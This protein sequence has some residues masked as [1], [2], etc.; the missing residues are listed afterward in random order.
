M[1][2]QRPRSQLFTIRLWSEEMG[3]GSEEEY[4]GQVV[5]TPTGTTRYFRSWDDLAAFM[6]SVVGSASREGES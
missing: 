5:H 3:P 4:R 2:Q 1:T 6:I